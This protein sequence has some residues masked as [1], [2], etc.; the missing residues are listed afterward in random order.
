VLSGELG[1]L[2]ETGFLVHDNMQYL[3]TPTA[4]PAV[5]NR[6]TLPIEESS[7]DEED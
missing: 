1:N 3:R 7:I 5:A 4:E 2:K 6:T